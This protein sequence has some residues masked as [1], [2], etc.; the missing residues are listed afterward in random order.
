MFDLFQMWLLVEVLGIACL[1]LT[2]AVFH[3]LPDRGWAFSK[4]LGLVVLAFAVW[5]PLMCIHILPFSQL[6]IIGVVLILLAGSVFGFLRTRHTLLKIFHQHRVY[7]AATELVFL[8]MVFVLGVIRS[9]GPNI[10]SYEMFMDEGFIASIMRSPHFPPNDMWLSGYSLNYYYYAHFT[11][12]MLAKVLGQSPSIAFNTGICIFFG[13]T[14]VSLFGVTSNIVAW[15]RQQRRARVTSE[16][17]ELL[18]SLTPAIPYGILTMLM[19]LVLGNLAST[20]EWFQNHGDIAHYDWMWKPTRVVDYTIN[21][22]PAFSFLLSCFHAHVLALAFTI[23]GIGLAFNLFLEP[24]GK[25]LSV[26]GRGWRMPVTLGITALLLGS[27]FTMNG[28]DYPTYVG[29][30]LVCIA[31]QQWLAYQRRFSLALLLDIAS[32]ALSLVTLSFLLY[33]PFYLNFSSPSR[34]IGLLPVT[35]RSQLS[36]ELLIY[37]LFAF[38]FISLLLAS[39]LRKPQVED[40]AVALEERERADSM[41]PVS[42]GSSEAAVG[43]VAADPVLW[44]RAEGVNSDT[45]PEEEGVVDIPA[46]PSATAQRSSLDLVLLTRLLLLGVY[47]LASLLV[48]RLMPNSATFLICSSIAVL[49]VVVLFSTIDDRSHAFILLLGATAFALVAACEIIYLRDAFDGGD[50]LRMNTVFKFYFQAWALL[51]IASGAGIFFI[52]ESFRPLASSTG[53][54]RWSQRTVFALWSL[55]ACLFIG[56]SVIYPLV[57]PYARYAQIDPQT[58]KYALKSTGSL[59]GLAYLSHDPASAGD[60]AAIRWLNANVQGDPVIV[61][62]FGDDYSVYGRISAFTGLPTLMGWAGHELQWRLN[63]ANDP[64]K[65]QDMYRRSGD[66]AQIYTDPNSQ[67]VVSL[68]EQY[69]VSYVYVGQLEHQKYPNADLQRFGTFMQVVYNA[70]GVII[71]KVR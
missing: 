68:L 35:K 64:T 1:P 67:Q 61:E 10:Q 5:F 38:L 62:A 39:V 20:Q 44:S 46:V 71:Y 6:F 3:N 24:D 31:L 4:V 37:G 32:P 54:L 23:V 51:S 52:L 19:G 27:L 28:W 65:G 49:A 30:A 40:T 34:G 69:K 15:A 45:L 42:A 12:A 56:A 21:E 8:G 47:I 58:Q 25:G 55:L 57:A 48:I 2:I 41:V 43:T 60:Y 63:W 22:F 50:Y 70:N 14:A 66:I 36:E 33:L 26:F 29:L 9:F 16:A 18:P 11:I 7:I 17:G 13:L 59:D 53:M